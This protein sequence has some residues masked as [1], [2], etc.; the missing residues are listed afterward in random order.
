[1]TAVTAGSSYSKHSTRRDV[2]SGSNEHVFWEDCKIVFLTHCIDTG[3]K[4]VRKI[5]CMGHLLVGLE[6]A[7]ACLVH[8]ELFSLSE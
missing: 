5:G 3:S 2:G 6:Q 1:M 4:S 8:R 7:F